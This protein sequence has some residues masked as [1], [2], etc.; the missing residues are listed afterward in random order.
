MKTYYILYDTASSVSWRI[1]NTLNDLNTSIGLINEI[2][3]M[4]TELGK[5]IIINNW[6]ELN[7]KKGIRGFF[8]KLFWGI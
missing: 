4:E 6:K 3:D 1:R 7:L 2:K 5:E 8:Q